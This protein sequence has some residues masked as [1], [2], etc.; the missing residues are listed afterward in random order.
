MK[1]KETTDNIHKQDQWT[2]KEVQDHGNFIII[3]VTEEETK[4]LTFPAYEQLTGRYQ[5]YFQEQKS[6]YQWLQQLTSNTNNNY[7]KSSQTIPH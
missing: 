2:Q 1:T 4:F 5:I 3:I 6:H 7:K